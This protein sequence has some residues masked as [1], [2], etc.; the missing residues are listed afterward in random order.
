VAAFA[1][2]AAVGSDA[3]LEGLS[4][5]GF[6]DTTRIAASD[7]R[8]WRDVLLSNREEVL[9]A[10]RGLDEELALLRRAI[11][12]GDGDEIERLIERARDGRK[13]ILRA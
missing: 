12:G 1:L 7:P 11:A 3:S 6:T 2:A 9:A 5:G 8:M 4:G 13:R 10:M